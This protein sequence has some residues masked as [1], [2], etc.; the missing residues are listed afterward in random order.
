MENL[1]QGLKAAGEATRLRILGLCAHAELTVSDLVTILGQSQPRVSR[2]LRLLVEAGLLE[3]HQEGTWA[4]YRL[5]EGGP[6]DPGRG[7]L[8]GD[9]GRTLV[10]LVPDDD[11]I[12][13]EDLARLEAVRA[14]RA[15]KA[16]AYFR[17]NAAEWSEVRALHVDPATV[18]Q[19][20]LR[21]L[22]GGG[23]ES[24]GDVLDI[25][26]GTGSILELAGPRADSAIGVDSSREMLAVARAALDRADLRHCQVRQAD[27]YQLPFAGERFDA[28]VMHMVLH[29]TENPE[30]AIA[31][32]VRVLRPGGKL[33]VADF[34]PHTMTS[35]TEEH[36]HRWLGFSEP[37]MARWFRAA[38][39]T[40]GEPE[41]LEG[42]PLTVC[43]WTG[44]RPAND[45]RRPAGKAE[46]AA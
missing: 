7:T 44:T 21:L 15:R 17:R 8:G 28:A 45:R 37:Q 18:E 38:G 10:D 22:G 39:L 12:L 30:Q 14:E 16:E 24:L 31:E 35:L 26:T 25:G 27:M 29:Y 13:S 34:A 23:D 6:T 3:R 9:L 42:T 33:V 20:V 2:H 5:A 40:A 32:A 43:I 4:W 41:R 19:A 36:A 11:P 46:G 1:L